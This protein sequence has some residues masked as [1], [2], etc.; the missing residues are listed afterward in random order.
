MTHIDDTFHFGFGHSLQRNIPHDADCSTR[1]HEFSNLHLAQAQ[2]R[3]HVA[4]P[5]WKFVG[6]QRHLV[7]A[8][9]AAKLP[10]GLNADG[11]AQLSFRVDQTS[12]LPRDCCI[13]MF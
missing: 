3:E 2:D 13:V 8:K 6:R 1:V 4:L 11:V 5:I 12:R 9:V 7:L 10:H